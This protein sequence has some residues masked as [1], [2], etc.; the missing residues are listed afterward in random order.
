M[1]VYLY[2]YMLHIWHDYAA[3]TSKKTQTHA[4]TT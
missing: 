3:L 1:Y 4:H 2:I